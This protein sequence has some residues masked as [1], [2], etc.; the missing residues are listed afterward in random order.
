MYGIEFN[1]DITQIKLALEV[2][3]ELEIIQCFMSRIE[4]LLYGRTKVV[5]HNGLL[6]EALKNQRNIY[7]ST[8]Y[9]S[10]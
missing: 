3:I 6:G 5:F 1:R 8:P 7:E 9:W 4:L 10:Y 2:L